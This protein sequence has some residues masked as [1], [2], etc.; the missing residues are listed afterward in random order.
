MGTVQITE[1]FQERAAPDLICSLECS[2]VSVRKF[3]GAEQNQRKKD[4]ISL[5]F[6]VPHD[7]KCEIEGRKKLLNSA[8]VK[9]EE[10][11][12]LAG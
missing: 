9:E 2:L 7:G 10:S 5:L 12:R 11:S 4:K 6:S 1:K 8:Y 3:F